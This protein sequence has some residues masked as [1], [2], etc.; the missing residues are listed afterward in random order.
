M[1]RRKQT[2]IPAFTEILL[3]NV[4]FVEKTSFAIGMDT[5]AA[6]I[7]KAARFRYM[8]FFVIVSYQNPICKCC[9]RQGEALKSRGLSVRTGN[10]LMHI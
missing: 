3:E 5:V 10:R 9:L 7:K 4:R 1:S 8:A 2:R 6:A